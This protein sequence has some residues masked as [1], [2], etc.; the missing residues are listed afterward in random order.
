MILLVMDF[1]Q[2]PTFGTNAAGF[3][4]L[5]F[6]YYTRD[7]N[8]NQI[9]KK[10]IDIIAKHE[11]NWIFVRQAFRT[12]Q[13]IGLFDNYSQIIIWSDGGPHHFKVCKT[14]RALPSVINRAL[15]KIYWEFFAPDHGH[16]ECDAHSG[17]LKTRIDSEVKQGHR[18][19]TLQ[20]FKVIIQKVP[21]TQVFILD[22]FDESD[23]YAELPGIRSFFSYDYDC[24]WNHI[25]CSCIAGGPKQCIPFL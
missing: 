6:C 16:S 13:Q 5:V 18:P 20:E 8:T 17:A 22:Q 10:N 23:L 3:N 12:L 1:T 25:N 9:I 4:D 19:A 15:K 21:N 14:L 7:P 24:E 2:L 11:H